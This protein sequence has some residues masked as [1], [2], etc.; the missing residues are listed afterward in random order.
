MLWMSTFLERPLNVNDLVIFNLVVCSFCLMIAASTD[1]SHL[2]KAAG[3]SAIFIF[4]AGWWCCFQ[5]SG[6][7]W[8]FHAVC[9][10]QRGCE[11]VRVSSREVLMP[12]EALL[13]EVRRTCQVGASTWLVHECCASFS[14]CSLTALLE[15]PSY[16]KE[17]CSVCQSLPTPLYHHVFPLGRILVCIFC[18]PL[19]FALLLSFSLSMCC[20]VL[21]SQCSLLL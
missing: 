9:S 15:P 21:G 2:R 20:V 14:T 3:G 17:G 5:V 13:W 1:C 4:Y 11:A 8:H 16:M 7:L 10:W 18:I 12:V 19:F 6:R